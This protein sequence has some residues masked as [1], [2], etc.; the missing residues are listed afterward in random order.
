MAES[1]ARTDSSTL[2]GRLT[3]DVDC[4][5]SRSTPHAFSWSSR[6]RWRLEPLALPKLRQ[7]RPRL[8][9]PG[10]ER[11]GKLDWNVPREF[12]TQIML[13]G[14]GARRWTSWAPTTA[15]SARPASFEVS[16]HP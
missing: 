2:P 15:D 14:R 10:R 9:A 1:L 16:E 5:G 3:S 12:G 4:A 11:V 6:P 7:H 13:L 8:R